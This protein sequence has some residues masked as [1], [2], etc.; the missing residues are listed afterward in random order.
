MGDRPANE[1][2][3]EIAK[4]YTVFDALIN[5]SKRKC[6]FGVQILN[7]FNT[8]WSEAQFDTET[9]LKNETTPVSELCFTP[10]TPFSIK[11]IGMYKF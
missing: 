4:G 5:Y 6:E 3:S 2:N 9:R 7:V 11:F 10:G 1:D 8:I